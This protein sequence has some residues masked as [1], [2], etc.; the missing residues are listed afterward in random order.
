ML[1]GIVSI[2]SVDY[3]L[4][5]LLFFV[6]DSIGNAQLKIIHVIDHSFFNGRNGS[7]ASTDNPSVSLSDLPRLESFTTGV[8]SFL[9]IKS[10]KL[11]SSHM[12]NF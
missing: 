1:V 8:S 5:V 11:R 3:V 9:F 12:V 2:I 7:D 4:R 10:L 6:I